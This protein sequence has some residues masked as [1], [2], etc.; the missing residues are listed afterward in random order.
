MYLSDLPR[1]AVEDLSHSSQLPTSN[2][3]ALLK[4]EWVEA[5]EQHLG[6]HFDH[7]YNCL[8]SGKGGLVPASPVES[9]ADIH[10]PP[11]KHALYFLSGCRHRQVLEIMNEYA[12]FETEHATSTA[13]SILPRRKA[14]WNLRV[15][16]MQVLRVTLDRD[17]HHVI[18]EAATAKLV[19]RARAQSA[20]N[21]S[22]VT[23]YWRRLC[24]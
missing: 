13:C 5:L 10:G 17:R 21:K 22:Y 14:Q 12:S 2:E 8:I 24:V 16:H 15:L 4:S 11:A 19:E 1:T 18:D 6:Y 23:A 20:L 7:T 3:T 9:A